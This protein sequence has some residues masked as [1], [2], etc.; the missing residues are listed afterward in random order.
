LS[1]VLIHGPGGCDV[2]GEKSLKGKIQFDQVYDEGRSWAG[3]EVVVRAIPNG[4]PLSRFG[5]SVSRRVGKAVVRNHV[6]R[7]LREI[8]R[9]LPVKAGSDIVL[10]ARVPSATAGYAALSR[11]VRGLLG[12]AGLLL[13]EDESVS[14]GAN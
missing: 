9:K 3:R 10:I 1:R 5:F 14:P 7:L 4:L 8:I 12:R 2:R 11:S 6:K 13:G